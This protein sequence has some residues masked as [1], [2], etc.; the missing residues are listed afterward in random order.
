[1]LLYFA[2]MI[3]DKYN[4]IALSLWLIFIVFICILIT[5]QHFHHTVVNNYIYGSSLWLHSKDLYD[6]TGQG[7]IYLPQS[8]VLFIP[9]TYLSFLSYP[10]ATILWRIVS[11]GLLA[12]ALY[13]F[14][15]LVK[16]TPRPRTFLL[17][18]LVVIPLAFSS[19]RN[20][21]FNI[22]ITVMMLF[23]MVSLASEKWWLATLFLV[24]GLALKPTM[25]VILL[26]AWVLY[27]PLWWRIP[28]GLLAMLAFPFLTQSPHYVITQYHNAYLMLQ[29]ASQVGSAGTN[30]AQLFGLL[31]R[32]NLLIPA[33]TQNIIRIIAALL[34]LYL[35]WVA[36]K[37]N[38][39][40][41]ATALLFSLAACYLM[42]FNPRTENN[43]YVILAPAI[44]YF[45][46]VFIQDKRWWL[47]C[48]IIAITI[49]F[50]F[51]HVVSVAITPSYRNWFAPLMAVLF[52]IICVGNIFEF[53]GVKK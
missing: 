12:Y 22:I 49:G 28:I 20:G 42:L 40:H 43:D 27:R 37:N 16:N 33:A 47:M 39:A 51:D 30:W 11:L 7:F 38:P 8:A 23:A 24:L 46:S 14:A 18:T 17:M 35:A 10:L 15:S 34:T 19:A 44:G 9:F 25:I 32:F 36:G 50:V 21:Q 41:R 4:K 45:L 48:L 3:T 13:G 26:L 6:N 29:Q 52:S 1:M 31:A 5:A 2:N 53:S